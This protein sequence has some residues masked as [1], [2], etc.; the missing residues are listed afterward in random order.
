MLYY[1][2]YVDRMEPVVLVITIHIEG[3]KPLSM[4]EVSDH[5]HLSGANR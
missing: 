2:C 1:V 3:V 4:K 5:Q